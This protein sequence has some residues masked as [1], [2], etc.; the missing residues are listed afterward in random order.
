[1]QGKHDYLP[2][3]AKIWEQPPLEGMIQEMRGLS[4]S[5][6]EAAPA[7]LFRLLTTAVR[8]DKNFGAVAK[9]LGAT[10]DKSRIVSYISGLRQKY[11]FLQEYLDLNGSRAHHA[12]G[13]PTYDSFSASMV[14]MKFSVPPHRISDAAYYKSGSR[15]R[16][17]L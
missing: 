8:H 6:R 16:H 1:M 2:V 4:D 3:S 11:P 5:L 13:V 14:R 15:D 7:G 17:V 12:Q 9:G 10:P